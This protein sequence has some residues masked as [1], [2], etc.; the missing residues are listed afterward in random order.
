MDDW[1]VAQDWSRDPTSLS[2][3]PNGRMTI[4]ITRGEEGKNVV[5]RLVQG[6][7]S[8]HRWLVLELESRM[9]AGGRLAIGLSSG[10]GFS[11][12]E[13]V[14]KYIKPGLTPEVVFDLRSATFKTEATD[15]KYEAK[16]QDLTDVRALNLLFYP[17]SGG[18]VIVH[19]MKLVK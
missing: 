19:S 14:P 13:S 10:E 2:V 18:T 11:Y 8:N 17:I 5:G 7:L 15:W 9:S 4:E 16:P 6:D 3:D 1:Q 12:C